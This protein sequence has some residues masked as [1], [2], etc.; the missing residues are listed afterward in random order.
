MRWGT[1]RRGWNPP[2][3]KCRRLL[4]P[5]PPPVP[6]LSSDPIG[7]LPI[8]NFQDIAPNKYYYLQRYSAGVRAEYIG[9]TYDLGDDWKTATT[10]TVRRIYSRGEKR[11]F[12][13]DVLAEH[14][15]AISQNMQDMNNQ[16][17]GI[18]DFLGIVGVGPH[19]VATW[20]E[21]PLTGEFTEWTEMDSTIT[22]PRDDIIEG[23]ELTNGKYSFR[24]MLG[25]EGGASRRRRRR[26]ATRRRHTLRR[27]KTAHRRRRA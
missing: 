9:S 2:I 14:G 3:T 26:R 12:L 23:G 16:S 18:I 10:V 21:L 19:Q 4:E 17:I 25:Q 5:M 1:I 20:S 15:I 11:K 7:Q 27:R 6:P 22:L 24:L 13:V 8:V